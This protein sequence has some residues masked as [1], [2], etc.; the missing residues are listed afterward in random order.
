MLRRAFIISY[1]AL[2]ASLTLTAAAHAAPKPYGSQALVRLADS[3]PGI[4]VVINGQGP[5]LFLIDTATSHTVV[6]PAVQQRLQLPTMP[7]PAYDVI[8]AAGSVRSRL[9][10]VDE[11]AAAGVIV[12]GGHAVVIDLPR[13][14]GIQG[15]LG[16]DFLSNFTV[17]L[18]LLRQTV[19]LYPEGTEL[20]P[21]GLRRIRGRVND[22]GFIIL[23]GRADN[24]TSAVI[25]DTG[26]QY[27]VANP[28]LAVFAQRTVK[29]IA[30]NVESRVV[31]AAR[32]RGW[33]ET[34]RFARVALG[35]I[36][37]RD[38]SVMIAN[39][40]VFAQI[41][42]ERQPAIFFGM[43]MIAGRR[44]VLEYGSAAIWLSP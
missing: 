31:D 33:A 24:V 20:R 28:A 14:F 5:F 37:W 43:D 2:A 18:D 21:P 19:T 38:R 32:Q 44:I 29:V 4:N 39:M 13:E 17:D 9:H 26:A 23:P 15:I 30:R 25:I 41:E 7:G 35:P 8:T 3:R 6:V 36:V 10:K 12:E 42:L 22:Y 1:L 16:A 40:R 11:I 27:T 34:L